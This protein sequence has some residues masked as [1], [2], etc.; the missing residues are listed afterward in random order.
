MN[1]D[2]YEFHTHIRL[3]ASFFFHLVSV[4]DEELQSMPPL[5]VFYRWR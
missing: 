5:G 2:E 4:E 1:R 3:G